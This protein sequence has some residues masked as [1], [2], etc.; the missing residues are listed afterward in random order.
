MVTGTGVFKSTHTLI[1]FLFLK[2][3][4]MVKIVG[5]ANFYNILFNLT[6]YVS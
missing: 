5:V 4:K 6:L 2:L 3:N 1:L